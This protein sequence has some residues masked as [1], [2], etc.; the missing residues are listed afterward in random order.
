M[1]RFVLH[2][3]LLIVPTFIG[4]TL[5]AFLFIRL[6]PGDPVILMA[7]ERGVSPERHA[8]LMAQFGFDQPLW[9]QY[10]DYVAGLMQGNFGY[11]FSTKKPVL[12][13]FMARFPATL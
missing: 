3:L 7:G 13:E 5:V 2:R 10:V 1:L 9:K 6:L 8:E 4:I 12:G 11:S